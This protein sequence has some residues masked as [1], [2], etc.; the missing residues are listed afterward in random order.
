M[1]KDF[2]RCI[3]GRRLPD[4]VRRYVA[5]RLLV[6]QAPDIIDEFRRGVADFPSIKAISEST[7]RRISNEFYP[8]GL[9]AARKKIETKCHLDSFWMSTLDAQ[10]ANRLYSLPSHT[11][12]QS[13]ES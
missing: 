4:P 9:E 13:N 8:D 2:A 12:I 6:W 5:E 3:M 10:A 7:I 11:N 1:K